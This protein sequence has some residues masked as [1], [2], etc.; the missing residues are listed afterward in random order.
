MACPCCD[1]QCGGDADCSFRAKPCNSLTERDPCCPYFTNPPDTST[2]KYKCCTGTCIFGSHFTSRACLESIGYTVG[3]VVKDRCCPGVSYADWTRSNRT[4]ITW[5]GRSA[6]APRD[7]DAPAE[8]VFFEGGFQHRAFALASPSSHFGEWR[9]A[10][11][12]RFFSNGYPRVDTVDRCPSSLSDMCERRTHV[13]VA[14]N[15]SG[16]DAG[17][18]VINLRNEANFEESTVGGSDFPSLSISWRNI[19]GC[20]NP[21]P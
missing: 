15:I 8:L 4:S 16:V 9:T 10:T 13:V 2:I 20:T 19:T 1:P 6:T 11:G 12:L 21:L 17:G 14:Y 7:G 18:K 3:G 5:K